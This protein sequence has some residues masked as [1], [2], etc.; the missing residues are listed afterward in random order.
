M[1][2]LDENNTLLEQSKALTEIIKDAL[3]VTKQQLN[4][5][6]IV[7]AISLLINLLTILGFLWYESQ[8]E[9]SSS[10]TAY[11]TTTTTTQSAEGENSSI[12]NIGGN[13]YNDNATHQEALNER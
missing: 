10:D 8:F 7:I 3:A 1:D 12:N 2:R 11:T 4:R 9:Y 5:A 6:Y 13:Q